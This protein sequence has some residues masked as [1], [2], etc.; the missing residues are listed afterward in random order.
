[1]IELH[2][3]PIPRP[4]GIAGLEI[5]LPVF[6]T[7]GIHEGEVIGIG[8]LTWG[9][10]RCFL[11]FH[12]EKQVPGA[13]LV[14]VREARRMIRKAR[15]LGETEIW[16]IRDAAYDTSERLLKI[17]GFEPAGEDNGKEAWRLSLL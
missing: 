15:Q 6:A 11:F 10:G 13:G 8:G 7:I 1:M 17:V 16:T 4:M 2:R 5:D 9:G 12:I 3:I 14:A